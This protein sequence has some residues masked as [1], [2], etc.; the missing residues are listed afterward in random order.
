[1]TEEEVLKLFEPQWY[2]PITKEKVNLIY[3]F[4][5]VQD[6]NV[7]PPLMGCKIYKH[8]VDDVKNLVDD[9]NQLVYDPLRP[10][11]VMPRFM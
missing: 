10:S 11:G 6:R 9:L 7:Q 2:N 3:Y 5:L 1:M 4:Y 8:R